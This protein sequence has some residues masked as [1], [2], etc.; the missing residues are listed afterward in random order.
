MVNLSQ[1]MIPNNSRYINAGKRQTLRNDCVISDVVLFPNS[2]AGRP[3]VRSFS[4]VW[5]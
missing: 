1:L 3:G 2:I 5:C 4:P